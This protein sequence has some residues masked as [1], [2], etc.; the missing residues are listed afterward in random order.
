MLGQPKQL[1]L[2]DQATQDTLEWV[3][4]VSADGSSLHLLERRQAPTAPAAPE[5]TREHTGHRFI[6]PRTAALGS[7]FV[8]N[9][10][11]ADFLEAQTGVI[12]LPEQRAEIVEKVAEY[13]MYKERWRETKGEIPDFKERVPPEIALE[14]CACRSFSRAVAVHADRTAITGSWQATTWSAEP[15]ETP[16]CI[17]LSNCCN[18]YYLRSSDPLFPHTRRMM[19]SALQSPSD[20]P[21]LSA[22]RGFGR[23]SLCV[24]PTVACATASSLGQP[25][26][27]P[28]SP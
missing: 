12:H 23:P 9:T 2:T 17:K 11:S 18:A 6:L 8:K 5:L 3:T 14:L 7:E 26:D 16:C 15:V 4:L 27:L 25:A 19:W 1:S 13:L 10:L 20:L 28:P 22:A 24:A 21:M